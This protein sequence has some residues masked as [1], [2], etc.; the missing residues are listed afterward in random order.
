[1]FQRWSL[2]LEKD[3]SYLQ[4]VLWSSTEELPSI[5][6]IL[7]YHHRYHPLAS[8]TAWRVF[9]PGKIHKPKHSTVDIDH[10]IARLNFKITQQ[11]QRE[12]QSKKIDILT[13]CTTGV[14]GLRQVW[15]RYK[16]SFS[17]RLPLRFRWVRH[18]NSPHSWCNIQVT[19]RN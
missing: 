17:V 5:P 2:T 12:N 6:T 4:L 11:S 10:L 7:Q 16:I 9:G 1:M 3:F 19:N 18:V 13:T 8:K 15:T 14:D